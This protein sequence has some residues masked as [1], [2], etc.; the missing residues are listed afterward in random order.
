[1]QNKKLASIIAL[2]AVVANLGVASMAFA[3]ESATGTQPI[4]CSAEDTQFAGTEPADF[5]FGSRQVSNNYDQ[6]TS[7]SYFGG[8]ELDVADEVVISSN[9]PVSCANEARG[10]QLSVQAESPF[11]HDADTSG[12]FNT[13]DEVLAN[14]GTDNTFNTSDDIAAI[15]SISHDAVVCSGASPTSC[16]SA[17][18][19]TAYGAAKDGSTNFFAAANDGSTDGGYNASIALLTPADNYDQ[20]LTNSIPASAVTVFSSPVGFDGE[21]TVENISFKIALPANIEVPSVVGAL[22]Y[23]TNVLYTIS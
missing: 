19:V 9:T 2:T 3:Q 6:S 20:A 12:D 18:G 5:A 14:V 4:N 7:S 13:D 22:N 16:I 11:Y 23:T 15:L 1:M 10:V 21:V 8:V 17:N